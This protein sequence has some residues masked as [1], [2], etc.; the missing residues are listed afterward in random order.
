MYELWDFDSASI[1]NAYPT[2]SAALAIVA[3]E[4]AE[5]GRAAV[6]TWVLLWDNG[7]PSKVPVAEGEALADLATRQ[8][9]AVGD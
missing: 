8:R 6:E 5:A 4:I 2:E 3:A 7:G 9:V 1:I